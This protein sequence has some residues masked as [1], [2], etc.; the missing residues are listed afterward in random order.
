MAILVLFISVASTTPIRAAKDLNHVIYDVTW[1]SD[2]SAR[3]E[4]SWSEG[5]GKTLRI[6]GWNVDENNIMTV[7]YDVGASESGFAKRTIA[8]AKLKTPTRIVLEEDTSMQDGKTV[9][10]FT[11][12]PES[13]MS[14]AAIKHLYDQGIINGYTDG[15][16][17]PNHSVS[18]AEFAK[19]L[20]MTDDMRTSHSEEV[21]F[22]DVATNHWAYPYISTLADK[23]IVNGKGDNRFDPSGTITVGEVLA[24]IDR[25]FTFYPKEASYTY[26]L[27]GH[28]SDASFQQLVKAGIVRPEDTFYEPYTP[29]AVATRE[30]CAI[31]LSR[32]LTVYH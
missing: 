23:G 25:S 14:Q 19:M 15:S 7:H 26:G 31:L 3:I 5:K 10:L 21:M 6:T 8:D 11:D 9:S 16:F 13:S 12:M 1:I 4:L 29:A 2:H 24:I 20:F 30:Q 28:W 17:K 32:V 22:S 18:R 27:T